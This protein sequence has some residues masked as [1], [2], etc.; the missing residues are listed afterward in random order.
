MIC[1]ECDGKDFE[2]VWK[3]HLL[4]VNGQE[5][6]MGGRSWQ[7]DFCESTYMDSEQMDCFLVKYRKLVR[8]GEESLRQIV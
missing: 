8:R 3:E 6:C 1:L 5:I 7:C 4:T 2:E